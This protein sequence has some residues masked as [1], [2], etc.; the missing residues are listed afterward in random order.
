MSPLLAHQPAWPSVVPAHP[1]WLVPRSAPEPGLE[2]VSGLLRMARGCPLGPAGRLW[3]LSRGMLSRIWGVMSFRMGP[4]RQGVGATHGGKGRMQ[5]SVGVPVLGEEAEP[6]S[7]DAGRPGGS[8]EPHKLNSGVFYFAGITP[9]APSQV[10]GVRTL[11]PSLSPPSLCPILMP[12]LI[13]LYKC[14]SNLICS[15]SMVLFLGLEA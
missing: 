11:L 10:L 2:Q 14:H 6:Q 13:R 4:P 8:L 9:P 15:P 1:Q 12:C 3:T 5:L 7:P